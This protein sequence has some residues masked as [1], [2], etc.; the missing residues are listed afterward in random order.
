[1][2]LRASSVVCDFQCDMSGCTF[3]PAFF[4]RHLLQ[5]PGQLRRGGEIT[6]AAQNIGCIPAGP[7]CMAAAAENICLKLVMSP[8][9]GDQGCQQLILSRSLLQDY[10][11]FYKT[12]RKLSPVLRLTRNKNNGSD[13]GVS[14]FFLSDKRVTGDKY[15]LS[16]GICRARNYIRERFDFFCKNTF[17]MNF[18]PVIFAP[19]PEVSEFCK[20][21]LRRTTGLE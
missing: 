8:C 20:T 15:C 2:N 4:F 17:E 19:Q 7:L 5:P 6:E 10:I 3:K 12:A 11:S 13:A 21:L 16:T 18:R 9:S 1:M 14:F